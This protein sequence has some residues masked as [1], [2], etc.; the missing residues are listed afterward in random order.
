MKDEEGKTRLARV[1]D[2]LVE[3]LDIIR[4]RRTASQFLANWTSARNE[5]K[6][7]VEQK[8]TRRV[9][10]V[11]V[12]AGRLEGL[13]TMLAAG[14]AVLQFT[15]TADLAK[16]YRREEMRRTKNEGIREHYDQERVMETGL[17]HDDCA[18]VLSRLGRNTAA[19]ESAGD[20]EEGITGQA[21]SRLHAVLLEQEINWIIA[22]ALERWGREVS[23]ARSL[24]RKV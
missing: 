6:L 4:V 12:V 1:S 7:A 19:R 10:W 17:G 20:R 24:E 18:A 23:R 9:L 22:T 8:N 21:W 2:C 16:R 11:G 15:M 13:L 3:A 5:G 14:R